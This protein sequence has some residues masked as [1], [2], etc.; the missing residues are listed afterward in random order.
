VTT[1]AAA[2][3]NQQVSD[4]VE[5]RCDHTCAERGLTMQSDGF[6]RWT[7][8]KAAWHRPDPDRG[9]HT[10]CGLVLPISAPETTPNGLCTPGYVVVA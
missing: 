3:P 10:M 7:L 9:F 8:Y 5:L 6:S 4:L 2:Y 1:T